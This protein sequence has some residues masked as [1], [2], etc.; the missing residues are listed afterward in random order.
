MF[1]LKFPVTGLADRTLLMSVKL[2]FIECFVILDLLETKM[3][4]QIKQY[5]INV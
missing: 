3:Y 4:K 2:C 1:H 5:D